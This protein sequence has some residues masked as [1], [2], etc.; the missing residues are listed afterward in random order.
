VNQL[1]EQLNK[2]RIAATSNTFINAI[3]HPTAGIPQ[4]NSNNFKDTA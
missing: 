3:S 1:I 4:P 2:S